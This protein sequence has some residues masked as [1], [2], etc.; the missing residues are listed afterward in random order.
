[1]FVGL[2]ALRSESSLQRVVRVRLA[3]PPTFEHAAHRQGGRRLTRWE[4]RAIR[5]GVVQ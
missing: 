4:A 5:R 3:R 1:M 2:Y